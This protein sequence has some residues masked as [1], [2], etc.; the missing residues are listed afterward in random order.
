MV[1]YFHTALITENETKMESVRSATGKTHSGC[2]LKHG[3]GGAKP[4]QA[5]RLSSEAILE[6]IGRRGHPWQ[7]FKKG[8]PQEFTMD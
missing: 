4:S 8:A 5:P 3:L 6:E 2:A 7:V 1:K